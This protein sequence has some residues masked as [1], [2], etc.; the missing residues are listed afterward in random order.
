MKF[1]YMTPALSMFLVPIS[2][3]TI[4]QYQDRLDKTKEE[5]KLAASDDIMKW[6]QNPKSQTDDCNRKVMASDI[7]WSYHSKCGTA[8]IDVTTNNIETGSGFSVMIRRHQLMKGCSQAV[9]GTNQ[10]DKAYTIWKDAS[11]KAHRK[12][13]V[14]SAIAYIEALDAGCTREELVRDLI[15]VARNQEHNWKAQDSANK[16]SGRN[17][18]LL[19]PR[20][21]YYGS[22]DARKDAIK[23]DM[24]AFYEEAFSQFDS[25]RAQFRLPAGQTLD[26]GQREHIY[27]GMRKRFMNT[28]SFQFSGFTG[29]V[30]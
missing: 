12:S 11:D 23:Q 13:R 14:D 22:D 2:G 21:V 10:T 24:I 16:N 25:E 9:A 19:T 8:G 27:D 30:D 28:D 4:A 17:P 18:D 3:H 5:E 20:D 7:D 1:L 15:D 29:M 26:H 6:I